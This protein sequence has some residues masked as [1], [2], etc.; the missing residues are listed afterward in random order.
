MAGEFDILIKNAKLRGSEENLFDIAI[1]SGK[2]NKIEKNIDGNAKNVLDAK[3]NLVT[4]SYVNAH[5][6]LCKVYTLLM[7][8]DEA[9]EAYVVVT[10][11]IWG[12]AMT[13][14]ELAMQVKENYDEKWIIKNVRK[15]VAL[16][17]RYGCTHMR[18]FADVD[19]KAKLEGVKALIKAK[20]EFKDIVDLQVVAFAQRRH[21]SRT[22]CC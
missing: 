6:H 5:L 3:G 10:A 18:V 9:I 17:A 12:K 14:I 22:R 4:E 13:A 11:L 15:A 8:G 16:A 2:I 19:N 7:M 20:N 21:C 1:S